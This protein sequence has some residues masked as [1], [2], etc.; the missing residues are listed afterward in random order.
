MTF[1][2]MSDGKKAVFRIKTIGDGF[3]LVQTQESY[4]NNS[5]AVGLGTTSPAFFPFTQT[6]SDPTYAL[7][8]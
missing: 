3:R 8:K 4:V 7:K 6:K 1:F 2:L 5:K